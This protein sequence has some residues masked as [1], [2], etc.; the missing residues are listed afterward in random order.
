MSGRGAPPAPSVTLTECPRCGSVNV[1]TDNV[2]RQ[3]IAQQ[4]LKVATD[5]RDNLWHTEHREDAFELVRLLEQL[6][7]PTAAPSA[8]AAVTADGDVRTEI[9]FTYARAYL[10]DQAG[11]PAAAGELAVAHLLTDHPEHEDLLEEASVIVADHWDVG[12]PEWLPE[13]AG[14]HI[15]LTTEVADAIVNDFLPLNVRYDLTDRAPEVLD[16][17]AATLCETLAG[18]ATFTEAIARLRDAA[19]RALDTAPRSRP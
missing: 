2:D 18:G 6:T 9:L 19:R 16:V 15:T 17:L 13:N 5:L 10:D 3:A 12:Y 1:M 4:A 8:A 11:E 14:D 7:G